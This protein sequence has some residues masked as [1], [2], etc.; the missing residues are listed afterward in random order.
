MATLSSLL[1]Y[2]SIES[3]LQGY[4]GADSSENQKLQLWW[5]QAVSMA[6][7]MLCREDW[8]AVPDAVKV[9]LFEAVRA[10]RDASWRPI[11]VASASTGAMSESYSDTIAGVSSARRVLRAL[12]AP[13]ALGPARL[14][15]GR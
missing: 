7:A 3:D 12:L 10:M 11:G 8:Q 1:P 4:L 5:A 14:F 15:W 9:A 6:D 13:Y 2:S